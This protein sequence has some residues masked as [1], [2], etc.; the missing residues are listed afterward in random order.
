M[1]WRVPVQRTEPVNWATSSARMASGVAR[2]WAW[3]LPITGIWGVVKVTASMAARRAAAAGAI[4]GLWA[5]ML[6]ARGIILRAPPASAARMAASMP[7]LSPEITTWPGQLSLATWAMPPLSAAAR[8][9]IS[10]NFSSSSPKT[11][12]IRPGD[13][14]PACFISRPRSRTRRSPS[15]RLRA[16]AATRAVYS[17]MLWPAMNWGRGRDPPTLSAARKAAM[18]AAIKAGWALTVSVNRSSG[19]LKQRSPRSKSNISLA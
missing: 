13:S 11:A 8:A 3:V 17:P 14:W 6:T 10:A 16:P 9:Q 1:A 2:C 7:I 4:N 19:P 5:A 12:A 15:S 18:L